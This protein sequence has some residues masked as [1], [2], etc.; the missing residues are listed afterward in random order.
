MSC[1]ILNTKGNCKVKITLRFRV[2]VDLSC[3]V[4]VTLMNV[5]QSKCCLTGSGSCSTKFSKFESF[6]CLFINILVRKIYPQNLSPF[7]IRNF[8]PQNLSAIFYPQNLSE[9]FIRKIY[10]QFLSSKFIRIFYPQNLSAK[11][12]RKIYPQFLS[13]IRTRIFYQ[14]PKNYATLFCAYIVDILNE[15]CQSQHELKITAILHNNDG[16]CK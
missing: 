14:T 5:V 7:F 16:R 10:P 1:Q 9:I 13:A 2:L 3:D 11:S 6:Q 8:Y 4:S 12:I 15:P